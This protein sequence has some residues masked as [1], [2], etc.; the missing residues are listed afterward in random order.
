VV[1]VVSQECCQ[2]ADQTVELLSGLKLLA[3][4]LDLEEHQVHAMYKLAD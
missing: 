4:S 3:M 2:A 1:Q